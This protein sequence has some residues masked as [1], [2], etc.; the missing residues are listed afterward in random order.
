[1]LTE[2]D[3]TDVVGLQVEG[4]ALQAGAELNHLSC[5][6]GVQTENSCDT[7]SNGDDITELNKIILRNERIL[8]LE[9][10]QRS[11]SRGQPR[12]LPRRFSFIKQ[13]WF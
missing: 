5:L 1:M 4:H 3:N 9:R 2:D 12:T 11:L 8:Q 7:V 6:H 13:E 10:F